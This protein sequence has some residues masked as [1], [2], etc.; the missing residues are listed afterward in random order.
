[1]P[2][3]LVRAEGETPVA[4]SA[5][6]SGTLRG[7]RPHACV[8]SF[9]TGTGRALYHPQER[10]LRVAS[11]RHSRKPMMNG[12]GQSDGSVVPEKPPNKTARAEAE[13]VKA[14][15]PAKGNANQQNAPRTQSR[16]EGAPSALERV[17][18][19]A[20]KDRKARFT[21]LFHHLSIERLRAAAGEIRKDAAAGVDGIGWS[22]YPERLEENLEG[23]HARLHR[24]A[25][26]AR[27]SR[28]VYTPKAD[29]RQRPL[30]I[31]AVEDKVVQRA[32]VGVLNAIYEE[33][34]LGFS[35]GF[36]PGR[37][38]HQALDALAVAITRK[39]VNWVLDTDI[40]D[41]FGT[42]DHGWL[43]KVV[44]HRVG[45]PRMVRL[46]Q[47][48]LKAGVLEDGKWTEVEQ[49]T[50]Q[51]A[52]V[53]PLLANLYLHYVLDLWVE[54]WRKRNAHGDV[55]V[56]RYADDLVVGFESE[57]DA[58]QFHADLAERLRK[59]ALELHPEKT[60]LIRFGRYA[61]NATADKP[62]TF[63]FLGLTHI[64]GSTEGRIPSA[65]ANG[66]EADAS[67]AQRHPRGVSAPQASV[68]SGTRA[69]ARQRGTWLFCVPRRPHKL[70]SLGQI[71]A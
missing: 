6:R 5:R 64:C 10:S 43:V 32:V 35:Y 39:K 58:R 2:T 15:G 51:G 60:R 14:R 31:A 8:E 29:G 20:R 50:P 37:N 25:Y 41:F 48:W 22:Q 7:R 1:M 45:D 44:E 9:C 54:Q 12:R 23:L 11:G 28:R 40:R 67:Q 63:D 13:G 24:G 27:P 56:V 68:H 46:I 18:Q 55:V 4:A 42:V 69:L 26:R 21:G 53:S 36:R 61:R 38:Q 33:D 47:K 34:F 52:T 19:A 3:L 59:F 49:G 65:E 17:R 66:S 16:K 71:S 57:R 30:G 62:E 70:L